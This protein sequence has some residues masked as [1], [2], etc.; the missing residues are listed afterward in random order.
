[1]SELS[2]WLRAELSENFSLDKDDDV[3]HPYILGVLEGKN[4]ESRSKLLFK[5]I[6]FNFF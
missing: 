4:Q 2:D 3:F 1:M 5:N 6:L